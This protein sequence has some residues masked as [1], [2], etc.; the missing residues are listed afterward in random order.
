MHNE[1]RGAFTLVELLVA[2]AVTALISGLMVSMV[3]YVMSSYNRTSGTLAAISQS[4]IIFSQLVTDL[5]SAVVRNK[6]EAMVEVEIFETAPGTWEATQKPVNLRFDEN[7]SITDPEANL[8]GQGSTRIRFFTAAPGF[9][10]AGDEIDSVRGVA[11]QVIYRGIT[12][13]PGAPNEFQ[14]YRSMAGSQETFDAGYDFAST[15]YTT[16][17]GNPN[18]QAL[19]VGTLL[20]PPNA[21]V[22]ASNIVDFGIRLLYDVNDDGELDVIFPRRTT[23]VT[24]ADGTVLPASGNL[25]YRGFGNR[26]TVTNGGSAVE[27]PYPEAVEVVVRVLT[28]EGVREINAIDAGLVPGADWWETAIRT[29]E[30][31]SQVITIPSKP[32]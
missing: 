20:N 18:T 14:I 8:Y 9:G 1:P 13:A 27:G 24:Q 29:S 30:A 26:V 3:S 11:Y 23:G 32:L 10:I 7:T 12:D 21:Y 15:A 31:F 19:T 25:T 6:N 5:E 16:P 17:E 22:L 2:L 4:S 28:P